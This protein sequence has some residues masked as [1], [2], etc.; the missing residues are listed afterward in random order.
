MVSRKLPMQTLQK[1]HLSNRLYIEQITCHLLM[2][3]LSARTC[4]ETA[5]QN[6]VCFEKCQ[7]PVNWFALQIGRLLSFLCVNCEDFDWF[8]GEKFSFGRTVSAD[9][10]SSCPWICGW[11]CEI[12]YFILIFSFIYFIYIYI[13]QG[14]SHRGIGFL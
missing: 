2:L 6:S 4:S 12:V 13:R 3:L 7:I 8:L 10:W 5:K 1:L 9:F 14:L 11:D